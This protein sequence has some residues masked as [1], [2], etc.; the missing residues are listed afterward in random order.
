MERVGRQS[1]FSRT[2]V[3]N[4]KAGPQ[5][6]ASPA[7]PGKERGQDR[8]C[9][10]RRT[11]GVLRVQHLSRKPYTG[12]TEEP[13]LLTAET[14]STLFRLRLRGKDSRLVYLPFLIAKVRRCPESLLNICTTRTS[15]SASAEMLRQRINC[16]STCV[17][18]LQ[19]CRQQNEKSLVS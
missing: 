2:W 16:N 19:K 18:A 10:E 17:I 14:K 5:P 1:V 6:Q 8:D 7:W 15:A 4:R 11:A 13:R 3:Q 9:I 12:R